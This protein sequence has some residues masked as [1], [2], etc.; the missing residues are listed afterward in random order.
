MYQRTGTLW[1]GRYRATL[2]DSESYLLTCYRYIELN[3]VRAA[4]GSE[5]G[6]YPW[7]SYAFHTHGEVNPLIQDHPLYLDLGQ[8]DKERRDAY[9]ALFEEHL[10]EATLQAVRE[11]TNNAWVLGGEKF[12][13][14]IQTT[15]QRRVKPLPR[16]GNRRKRSA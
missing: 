15:L 11:A 8:S 4:L 13:T 2:I 5:P 12:K 14:K 16:G 1:E 7:S 3:P 10:S 6:D 9:R